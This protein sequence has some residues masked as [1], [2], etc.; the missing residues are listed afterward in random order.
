MFDRVCYIEFITASGQAKRLEGINLQ[1]SVTKSMGAVMNEADITIYNLAME[2]IEYLTTFTSQ[3]IAYSKRKRL[4]IFAGYKDTGVGLIFDGDIIEALPSSPPD[5][6]LKC[7]ARSGAYGNCTMIS[8]SIT[9]AISV[10]DLLKQAEQWTGLTVKDTS[11]TTRKVNGFYYTGSVTQL[12]G[13]LNDIPDI[14]AYEDDGS[15]C[16][17]D[18]KNVDIGT[19]TRLLNKESGLIGVPQPDAIGI[20]ATMLLDPSIKIGQRIKIES[21]LIPACNGVYTIYELKHHGE[22]R[23]SDF[24]TD[25]TARR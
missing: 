23:G 19:Q 14:I 17:V 10:K 21:S 1:F 12:I 4:R 11:T 20:K 24:C 3:W 7:K 5:I 13:Q 9:D 2:D 15:L 8:Q 6:A 22:L 18:R 25:I 16:V